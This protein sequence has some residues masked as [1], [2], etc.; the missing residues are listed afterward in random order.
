MT[1]EQ[2]L[3]LVPRFRDGIRHMMGGVMQTPT[4]TVQLTKVNPRVM[5][6]NC[7]SLEAIL[8]GEPIQKILIDGGSGVNVINRFGNLS[9]TRP[10]KVGALYVLAANGGR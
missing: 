7:P 6:C 4:T 9:A 3:R 10:R 8:G 2:L 5:D 1:L